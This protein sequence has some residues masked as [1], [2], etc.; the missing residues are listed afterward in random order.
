M[1]N[2]QNQNSVF[3]QAKQ[4]IQKLQNFNRDNQSVNEEEIQAVTQL[5]QQ[6]YNESLTAEEEQELRDL[7]AKINSEFK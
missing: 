3:Q 2:Q 6:A 5:I 1:A 7:E 4:A